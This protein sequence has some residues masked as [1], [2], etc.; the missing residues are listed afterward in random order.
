MTDTPIP[1]DF[2]LPI[3]PP[4][5]PHIRK[6]Y[7]PLLNEVEL[8]ECNGEICQLMKKFYESPK[9]AKWEIAKVLKEVKNLNDKDVANSAFISIYKNIKAY[10]KA[11]RYSLH[12]KLVVPNEK[13]RSEQSNG[14]FNE[15]QR[16]S[17]SK[18]CV[19]S[20]INLMPVSEDPVRYIEFFC[21]LYEEYKDICEITN[22]GIEE[23]CKQILLKCDLNT[24]IDKCNIHKTLFYEYIIK[25]CQI[26]VHP[27]FI[28]GSYY[29][30]KEVQ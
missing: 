12:Q 26:A 15:H 25:D 20:I 1:R 2:K 30:I 24:Q 14:S 27:L 22:T 5:I 8:D 23:I 3:T 18:G 11:K 6:N 16:S 9:D 4:K 13:G 7:L 28:I 10:I 29:T 21:S 19:V 17:E